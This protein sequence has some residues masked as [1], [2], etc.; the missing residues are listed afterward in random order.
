MFILWFLNSIKVIVKGTSIEFFE[1]ERF[2]LGTPTHILIIDFFFN[3]LYFF[4]I[5]FGPKQSKSMNVRIEQNKNNRFYIFNTNTT[6]S[7][8]LF[9]FGLRSIW[10]HLRFWLIPIAV[11]VIFIYFSFFLKSLP[12]AKVV[13][14]YVMLANLFYV[15]ISGFIF[16]IKK[17]QYRLYTSAI[18]RF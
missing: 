2:F 6:T 1:E 16:F 10:R 11:A 5:Y 8:Q 4:G 12:F 7:T 18:Q 15:F 3:V 17:Y 14:A 13:F 9:L